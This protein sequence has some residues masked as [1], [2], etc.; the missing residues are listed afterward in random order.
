MRRKP[1]ATRHRRHCR[2][3]CHGRPAA[4]R[5][6]VAWVLL[7]V[8]AW[9]LW[10]GLAF[11]LDPKV[12]FQHYRFDHWGTDEGLPQIS[13]ATLAQGRLGY[14][15]IGT[16]NGIARFD[17][18]RFTVFDRAS[19]GVDTTL[20][21][22][23]LAAADGRVW[24]GTPR[25][26][27]WIADDGVH[28]VGNGGRL[29]SIRDLAQDADGRIL[30][31]NDAGLFVVHDDR[32][33]A[34]P[35]VAAPA[36]SLAQDGGVVWVGGR[37]SVT[38]VDGERSQRI[39]LP[40]PALQ[41]RRIT[42]DGARLWLGTA[43]GLKW[44]DLD[45]HTLMD[46]PQ[47]GNEAIDSL[48][49]DKDGNLWVGSVDHLRRRYP[50]G[51]W[52]TVADGDLFTQPWIDA[53]FEDREGGLWLGSRAQSLTRLRDSAISRIG[54]REGLSDPFVWSL[55]RER[56]GTL[57]LGTSH[58][59]AGI[60]TD[61]LPLAAGAADALAHQQ[62]YSLDADPDGSVWIGTRDGGV[63]I[64][65]D[66]ILATPAA[67]A[68]LAGQTVTAVQRA[69]DDGHWIA[70]LNGLH[71]YRNGVLRPL[72]PHDGSAAAKVR[73][74]LP[75]SAS[76][77]LVGTEAGIFRLQGEQLS[78]LPGTEALAASFVT[79]MAWVRP[80]LL[81]IATMDHGL[82]FWRDG[83]LLLLAKADGLPSSNGWTLDVVGAYLY[84]ASIDGVYR[85]ALADLPD[86][87]A[88]TPRRSLSAQVVIDGSQRGSNGRRF[89]CCNGGGD[90]RSLREG[91]IL[92]FASGAGAVRLD[93]AALP[94]PAAAPA[95]AIERVRNDTRDFS[96]AAPIVL[97]GDSRDLEIHYT[98]L[99]LVDSARLE[100]RYRL[101]GYDD[102]WHVAGQRRT[103]YYT[104]LPPGHYQ[105]RVQARPAFADW[106]AD[107]T[108]L[109]ITVASRW[110]ERTWVRLCAL[111]LLLLVVGTTLWRH[112]GR[113]R[114]RARELRQAVDER[115]AEL[116]A[117]NAR[118]ADLS[119]TDSLTGLANRRALD[120]TTA[121]GPRQWTGAVLLIDLDHFKRVND[122]HGHAHGDEV[123]VA[124]GE[125]LRANTRGD[126]LVL[127][128]GGEEFLVVSH[129]LDID[130]A[131]LLAE[132]IRDTLAARRFRGHDGR[133]MQVTCSIGAASLPVHPHRSGDL[134][135]SIA[136]ADHA[137]YRAKHE[138]RDR[139]L[140]AS[141]PADAAIAATG[142]LRHDI[143][144]LD[145]LG[146][147]IWRTSPKPAA[148]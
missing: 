127:R 147:L 24:F 107:V 63:T 96:G 133:P 92:W 95:T 56:D 53:I 30:A 36:L 143:E 51:R 72:G 69:G 40:D 141:V 90:G 88:T 54:A 48:L 126:D 121:D 129:R 10:P 21:T 16:Q 59:L 137:L 7:A 103:A 73:T 82:G 61:G 17:G 79:R 112:N 134:E 98:G 124:M 85:I 144:R 100:F 81:A 32:L 41:V 132:R 23:S 37:G 47:A 105:F 45:T 27:L 3:D 25:G 22:S 4:W 83:R 113:L 49:L 34:V 87:A 43:S 75:L 99:S 11:A 128:W 109:S 74:I 139:A 15:W 146:L 89:G 80:G 104:H 66:G 46:V 94:P 39:A 118:L 26:V 58:G 140:A 29:V 120:T 145:A 86:P 31:A 64:R 97:A 117:A 12:P 142:D 131:L 1:T 44:L 125:A 67:L 57:L 114:R 102:D 14:L 60:G 135:A 78:R 71:D 101:D 13:V 9:S 52:E 148:R 68:P 38:R 62:I 138:G 106:G 5:P 76:A 84:V 6:G 2:P 130:T 91:N 116:V 55:L 123:L 115:T 18:N 108:P 50:D 19:S 111:A 93:T 65:R 28:E 70:T 33:Q 20:P 122:E 119:R 136:L 77:A 42:R 8:L 35:E 110:H